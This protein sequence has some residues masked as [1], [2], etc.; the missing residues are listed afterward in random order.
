[1]TASSVRAEMSQE[2][3]QR[4]GCLN[5]SFLIIPQPLQSTIS[6]IVMMTV[7]A[8]FSMIIFLRFVTSRYSTS[9]IGSLLLHLYS[10]L[11]FKPIM[12]SDVS[13]T[14]IKS[15][16]ESSILRSENTRSRMVTI[17]NSLIKWKVRR[18]KLKKLW[19]LSFYFEGNMWPSLR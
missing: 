1:M 17:W 5:L 4:I 19:N 16:P 13:A 10:T 6:K 9:T 11:V 3:V 12:V 18:S 7:A 15:M 14:S 8:M 2:M